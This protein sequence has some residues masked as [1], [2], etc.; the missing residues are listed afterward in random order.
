MS[1]QSAK[2]GR[3]AD[4]VASIVEELEKGG[5]FR[6]MRPHVDEERRTS[7]A[8]HVRNEA[9]RSIQ[10]A[11]LLHTTKLPDGYFDG[12]GKWV[13]Q[14]KVTAADY[15]KAG[16]AVRK[17]GY[18]EVAARWEAT[19]QT[20]P[21]RANAL[22][23]QCAAEAFDLMAFSAA[24]PTSYRV[25]IIAALIHEAVTG[26]PYSDVY[27]ENSAELVVTDRRKHHPQAFMR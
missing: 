14:P 2:P 8:D 4:L 19:R 6:D 21:P 18:T 27:M 3:D 10:R 11:R 12:A 17:L 24:K 13:A 9:Q 1:R 7:L 26:K 5:A 15:H 25:R 22:K 23:Y 16:K 20:P